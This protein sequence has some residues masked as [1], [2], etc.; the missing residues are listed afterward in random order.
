M[1]EDEVPQLGSEQTFGQGWLGMGQIWT[2]STRSSG[3]TGWGRGRSRERQRWDK[4]SIL[5]CALL[6]LSSPPDG[7][8]VR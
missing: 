4:L 8:R 1:C 7:G 3:L 2:F 6:G 5:V